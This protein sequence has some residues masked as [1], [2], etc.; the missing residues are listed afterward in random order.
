MKKIFFSVSTKKT[1]LI[2]IFVVIITTLLILLIIINSS[3]LK[4]NI[5]S[6]SMLLISSISALCTAYLM[7]VKKGKWIA[8]AFHESCTA[9]ITYIINSIIIFL[10]FKIFAYL[11]PP[12]FASWAEYSLGFDTFILLAAC[13]PVYLVFRMLFFFWRKINQLKKQ[14]FAWSLTYY[15]LFVVLVTIVLILLLGI[16]IN[17]ILDS[18]SSN[19]LE[20]NISGR[21]LDWLVFNL[22]PIAAIFFGFLFVIL[23]VLLPPST[24][25]SFIFARQ[26]TCRLDHLSKAT[27]SLRKGN[28]QTRSPI[29]GEDEIA[30]LQSDFNMMAEHLEQSMK[31]IEKEK[32]VV[33]GLLKERK[34]LVASVS[35]ELRTPIT[36]IMNYIDV[37]QNNISKKKNPELAAN[38]DVIAAETNRLNLIVSDLF[39]L[40]RAEIGQLTIKNTP[41]NI[42]EIIHKVVE[43]QKPLAWQTGHV[44]LIF[45]IE[46]DLPTIKMDSNRLMQILI[47]LVRNGI[48]HTPPGGIVQI[49]ARRQENSI[50]ISVMDT[51]EGIEADELLNI[52]QRFYKGRHTT[53]TGIGLS[54]V[55]ELTEL[56]G[57]CI[58]VK[59]EVGIGTEFQLLFPITKRNKKSSSKSKGKSANKTA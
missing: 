47:N 4:T 33:D 45:Q 54:V 56:M 9:I 38:L 13:I 41:C 59:S 32:K 36:T 15:F 52:W 18:D 51:G 23:L 50:A 6:Q 24:V 8:R 7:Q 26:I 11:N 2:N 30:Q 37:I 40:S 44:D 57:G 53:G 16:V 21:L 29:E 31:D 48:Q 28:Y 34:E 5:L 10:I 39:D 58:D 14:H 20:G 35:H 22:F 17:T 25:F 12:G 19:Y 42:Q 43:T 27:A 55:K 49:S 3:D 46:K 1:L